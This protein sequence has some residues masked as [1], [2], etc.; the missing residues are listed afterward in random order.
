MNRERTDRIVSMDEKGTENV[1][2]TY[3]SKTGVE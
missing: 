3:A 2:F 1:I